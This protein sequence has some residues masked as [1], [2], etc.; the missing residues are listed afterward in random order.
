[1]VKCISFFLLFI[2]TLVS[3]QNT[4][5]DFINRAVENS[6]VLKDYRYQ[7]KYN[8]IQGQINAAENSAF[9]LSLTSDYLFV[10]YFNNNGKLVTTDPLPT[11][12]GYDINLFDGGLYSAQFNV[13]RNIFNGRLIDVLDQ[14]IRIQDQNAG[15]YFD[16]EKHNL[17]KVVTDQYLATYQTLLII[18][19]SAEIVTNLANQ[20]KLTGEL[21]NK[22]F[23]RTQDYLLLK[24]ELKN[25][26]INLRDARQNYR[27]NLYQ[28]YA[29]CGIQDTT[30]ADI[31]PASLKKVDPAPTSNFM[32]KFVQDSL[33]T[34]NEQQLFELKYVPQLSLFFN[35]GLNAITLIDIQR[36]FGMSAGLS[37][38]VPLYDGQQKSLTR[39][40]S[41]LMQNTISEY[42]Q[43]SQL[44]I[45]M[46]RKNLITQIDVLQK[47]ITDFT[48][49]V[50][51]FEKLLKLS[52]RQLQQ[53][54]TSIMDHL[55]L[56][57]NF[58]EIQKNKIE[59]EINYQL[60]INN[61]NYWNW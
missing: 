11:A 22:G 4:L 17:Q 30:V 57:R 39:Q 38:S 10:P 51:D 5:D 23:A 50:S 29:L 44:N 55:I 7:S 49:Q 15:Y 6:P 56:L 54:N 2:S 37:L 8:Q 36:K 41:A 60:Q 58:M 47:N 1:M 26:S 53:G 48:E 27:S 31:T 43:F 46:Q 32:K 18:R 28:L 25:Q 33:V 61:Y 20:L 42:R 16:L 14:Q 52:E 35:A 45:T 24:I 59:T 9:H 40:K 12:I 3:A 34:V 13:G 19:L 21:I